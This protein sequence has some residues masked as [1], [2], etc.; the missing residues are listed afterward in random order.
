MN[1]GR[2]GF[3]LGVVFAAL[4]SASATSCPTGT[5]SASHTVKPTSNP[6]KIG[7]KMTVT[8][9][10][11]VTDAATVCWDQQAVIPTN[12][13]SSSFEFAVPGDPKAELTGGHTISVV[14]GGFVYKA[15]VGS[16]APSSDA[17]GGAA[18]GTGSCPPNPAGPDYKMSAAPQ[19]AQIGQMMNV[20][21]IPAIAGPFTVYLDKEAVKTTSESATTF[22]FIVPGDPKKGQLTGKHTVWV[23]AGSV[24]YCTEVGKPQ[25]QLDSVTSYTLKSGSNPFRV[26]LNGESLDAPDRKNIK[27]WF[28]GSPLEFCWEDSDC[29]ARN[30]SVHASVHSEGQ[31]IELSGIDPTTERTAPF[32]VTI[33]GSST[34]EQTDSKAESDYLLAIAL[35]SAAT[36]AIIGI[37]IG[38]VYKYLRPTKIEGDDYVVRAL[39]MDKETNTYSLSKLQF[40]LWTIVAVFGYVFLALARNWFQHVYGLPAVPTGLPGIVAIAGGTAVGAQIVTNINGP[41]GAG[42]LKPSLADFVTSGDVVAAERVQF[43]IWTI[44]GAVGFLMVVLNLDPRVLKDL[45]DVPSSILSI[46]GLSAFGYL[47]GK[48]ARD[49][50]PVVSEVMVSMGP[51]P[52]VTTAGASVGQTAASTQTAGAI[53]SAKS[54]ISIAR[55]T[56][57]A[58]TTSTAVQPVINAAAKAC[59]A[60]ESLVKAAE[61]GGSDAVANVKKLAGG[62][63]AASREAASAAASMLPANTA[64][65]DLDGARAAATAAQQV[66]SVAQ[67]LAAAT[68]PAGAVSSASSG[69]FGLMRIRG[70]MLSRDAN[71]R[72]STGEDGGSNEVDISFDQLQP[73]YK[74]DQHLKKPRLIEKDA[75]STDPDMA[76]SLLLVINMTDNLRDVLKPGS[77]HIVTVINPDSQKAIFKFQLPESQKPA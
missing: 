45:P 60:A 33:N 70:R 14:T 48:L 61:A 28:N 72:V 54:G 56:L 27:I 30:L 41:K 2:Q 71:F 44:I 40:Y 51:D 52:E 37:V 50:G 24:T 16:S 75:D 49:P 65:A 73:S 43:F 76:K 53:A 4:V 18:G 11:P 32:S 23:V 55:Q 39:F 74:D 1:Y 69:L 42:Q 59:D 57:Q 62:A 58:I 17:A 47:G 77:K 35:S 36:L 29:D 63:D 25:L 3:L 7:Q 68:A 13:T 66:S 19:L 67:A 21:I 20:T 12:A 34:D 8:I 10:P 46:S 38:L 26:R 5:D 15:A 22:Q 9:D 31:S 64:K 6:Q